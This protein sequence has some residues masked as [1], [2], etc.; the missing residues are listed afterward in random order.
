L[1][2]IAKALEL[3]HYQLQRNLQL[4]E[5]YE[6][7]RIQEEA[8]HFIAI[9]VNQ[10]SMS[11]EDVAELNEKTKNGL[12]YL[13][14]NFAGINSTFIK[15]PLHK[16]TAA[17]N[18]SKAE[19][20]KQLQFLEQHGFLKFHHSEQTIPIEFLHPREDQFVQNLIRKKA[21]QDK[22]R[23][24]QKYEGIVSYLQQRDLCRTQFINAHFDESSSKCNNCDICNAYL[25]E[26]KTLNSI[27]KCCERPKT[28]ESLLKELE[29]DNYQLGYLLEV[30]LLEQ[31]I[32]YSNDS[33]ESAKS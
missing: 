23:K 25:D 18:M 17:F 2:P 8:G 4:L 28:F 24:I 11:T 20:H 1:T 3:E 29:I 15:V 5:R 21:K 26:N 13:I 30:L 14:R 27:I 16:L 22:A 12:H 33:Y 9:Q 10:R 32:T 6:I 31:K 7:I 19:L